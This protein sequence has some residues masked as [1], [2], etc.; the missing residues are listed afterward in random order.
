MYLFE[1]EYKSILY[2]ADEGKGSIVE[3]YAG[4]E[5]E[6]MADL[7]KRLKKDGYKNV[8]T[9]DIWKNSFATYAKN[10]D[11]VYV[12]YY[13]DIKEMRIVSE[14]ESQYLTFK[15]T[16]GKCSVKPLITQID[17]T[18]F[19]LSYVIRM[20]DGRFIIFD[21]GR[22]REEEADSLIACLRAQTPTE[23]PII[24]AWIMTHPHLDHY[25]AYFPFEEKYADE[26]VIERFIYNFPDV[27]EKNI[28]IFSELARPEREMKHLPL[29]EEAV[30]RSGAPVYRAHTGQKYK[31]GDLEF[32]ILASPD[33]A[34][35]N[36]SKFNAISLAMKVVIAG[37]TVLWTGDSQ[38]PTV[39]MA[40]RWGEYLK[41]DIYQV[42]HHGFPGG[43]IR[44]YSFIDPT[45]CLWPS[46]DYDSFGNHFYY[47]EFNLH[48][49]YNLHV[50]D[51]LIGGGGTITIEMPYT[52]RENG[53]KLF[54]DRIEHYQKR[55][56][57]CTWVFDG[58][59][60]A[61]ANF[62]FFA[63]GGA[64]EVYAD[65]YF[66]DSDKIVKDVKFTLDGKVRKKNLF[67]DAEESYRDARG[68]N[69]KALG[70][71]EIADDEVFTVMFKAERPL[72]IRG[73][74]APLYF[75]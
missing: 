31:I 21:G 13:P 44:A 25:Y 55:L 41:S 66:E 49:I 59:T 63:F 34:F 48:L 17:L 45:V 51:I 2:T 54:F 43:D 28:E 7:L 62:T 20:A 53:K 69:L 61:D 33:D 19:G 73:V 4:V 58:L 57:A 52:P 3:S 75:A 23:K 70:V 36:P 46:F 22:I 50:K 65:L 64:K 1:N 12:A 15:D 71:T 32:E 67:A 47:N 56:G 10:G 74:K 18:D 72:I 60:K 11:A 68:Y 8:D 24:A 35:M 27:T 42:T 5:K 29:F 16:P 40:D 6:V 37:Q 14:P 30:K 38:F 9:Y 26:C 39:K